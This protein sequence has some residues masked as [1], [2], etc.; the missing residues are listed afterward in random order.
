MERWTTLLSC[1][2]SLKYVHA[3]GYSD[4]YNFTD[5]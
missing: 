1:V 2:S 5:L 3:W 4:V